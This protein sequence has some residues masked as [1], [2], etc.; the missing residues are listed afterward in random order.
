MDIKTATPAEIDTEIARIST[1]I[2]NLNIQIRWA[3]ERVY[4]WAGRAEYVSATSRTKRGYYRLVGTYEEAAEIARQRWAEKEAWHAAGAPR[5]S[6]PQWLMGSSFPYSK[7]DFEGEFVRHDSLVDERAALMAQVYLL[8]AEYNR[9]GGWS[10]FFLVTSSQGHIHSTTACSTC[11]TYRSSASFG[12]LPEVS[13]KTEAEA[14]AA[15]GETLCSVC[16]PSA[17]VAWQTGKKITAAQAAKRVAGPVV[18]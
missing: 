18:D 15:H 4:H 13:G 12:W 6:Y 16:F 7:D 9:R 10:R 5:E 3:T 14:V 2:E 1:E 11:H 8:E 17:P